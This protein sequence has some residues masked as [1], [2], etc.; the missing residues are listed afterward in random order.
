MTFIGEALA[1]VIGAGQQDAV[2]S[3][4]RRSETSGRETLATHLAGTISGLDPALRLVIAQ[5]LIAY[6]RDLLVRPVSPAGGHLL[7]EAADK[8]RWLTSC[9]ETGPANDER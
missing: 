9:C 8:L 6:A 2:K 7:D 3:A 4:S 1:E 5:R